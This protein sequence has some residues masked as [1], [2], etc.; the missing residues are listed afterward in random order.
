MQTATHRRPHFKLQS[1]SEMVP[2][3]EQLQADDDTSLESV[4]PGDLHDR[5]VDNLRSSGYHQ[6]RYLDVEVSDGRIRL[7]GQLDRYYLL[8]VA[9]KTVLS[10]GGVDE[11]ISRVCV[12]R[13][14]PDA[15]SDCR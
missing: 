3:R 10:T 6:L 7:S 2:L 12:A 11:L 5:V 1:S 4:Q 9:H 14:Q 13:R 8:Q 15:P